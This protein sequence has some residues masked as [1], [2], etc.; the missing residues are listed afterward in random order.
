MRQILIIGPG[1]T[2][3]PAEAGWTI[4][5][6][7]TIEAV[8][9]GAPAT[10]RAY[11]REVEDLPTPAP[12]PR[13]A[14]K[15]TTIL[16]A[17]EVMLAMLESEIGGPPLSDRDLAVARRYRKQ[18]GGSP[19]PR[20][21]DRKPLSTAAP[22]TIE[23]IQRVRHLED[24]RVRILTAIKRALMTTIT[25]DDQKQQ[26]DALAD[27]LAVLV[28][29]L[30]ERFLQYRM[31]AKQKIYAATSHRDELRKSI[32]ILDPAPGTDSREEPRGLLHLA[33]RVD[34]KESKADLDRRRADWRL[35]KTEKLLA[36]AYALAPITW[37]I[38][39]LEATRLHRSRIRHAIDLAIALRVHRPE[40]GAPIGVLEERIAPLSDA[41]LVRRIIEATS[42]DDEDRRL[43][44][45]ALAHQVGD[46]I[47]RATG[48][49]HPTYL[50]AHLASRNLEKKIQRS[51]DALGWPPL[52]GARDEGPAAAIR[53]RAQRIGEIIWPAIDHREMEA[54][55]ARLNNDLDDLF[56]IPKRTR[57]AAPSPEWRAAPDLEPTAEQ[58]AAKMQE[59]RDASE[60]LT[61]EDAAVLEALKESGI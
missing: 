40:T 19:L 8:L 31:I 36:A 56:P 45:D 26:P 7:A 23:E 50:E 4:D 18:R 32:L 21:K 20:T 39:K 3:P 25:I 46:L 1:Q 60:P 61:A 15:P 37:H 52:A 43:L 34:I 29:S 58:I 41:D 48:W 13:R 10:S 38:E 2:A 44:R 12:E 11:A 17:A 55:L 51:L 54:D 6:I 35:A 47:E 16:Q 22:L 9:H 57:R 59:E 24:A 5:L 14:V 27:G 49:D 53:R 42:D 33:E 30:G 28:V